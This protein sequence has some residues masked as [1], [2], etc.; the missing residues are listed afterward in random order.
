MPSLISLFW[1]RGLSL[2]IGLGSVLAAGAQAQTNPTQTYPTKPIRLVIAYPAGAGVDLDARL[3]TPKLGEILGQPVIVENRGGP[4]SLA[5]TQYVAD[6][7]PDGYTLL[8][9]TVSTHALN[10]SLYKALPYDPITS[11]TPIAR[12]ASHPEFLAVPA[13]SKAHSVKEL[14]ALA[15]ASPQEFNYGSTG[16]GTLVHLMGARFVNAAGLNITHIPY[17]TASQ[18]LTAL[19]TGETK[20][21]IYPYAAL[22]PFAEDGKVRI[23]ATTGEQRSAYA[24]DVPTMA[25]AGYPDITGG[26]WSALY[27]PRGLPQAI[28]DKLYGAIVQVLDDPG[29]RRTFAATGTDAFLAG[30]AELVAF[31]KKEIVA[32][33]QDIERVGIKP[34]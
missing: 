24:P 21:M 25:E 5:G 2:L 26:S 6:A 31:N 27:G 10:V 32:Q 29:I 4:G 1:L 3:I 20:M 9:A 15:K 30:P 19:V 23:L 34:Q 7:A 13:T 16:V 14:V 11:F 17:R 33:R 18:A 22:K 8:L 28:S 12:V